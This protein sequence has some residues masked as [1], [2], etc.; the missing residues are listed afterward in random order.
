MPAS[1]PNKQISGRVVPETHKR[2]ED[3]A[4][5]QNPPLSIT[6]LMFVA[7]AEYMSNHGD[8]I[9]VDDFLIG[10]HGG[11]RK[12][13][14]TF[15]IENEIKRL[16]QNYLEC[17]TIAEKW[18]SHPPDEVEDAERTMKAINKRIERLN[19]ELEELD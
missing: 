6:E 16:E 18:G 9:A 14:E 5:A 8:K 7:I 17:Q 2:V 3:F 13:V 12:R 19:R 11:S 15:Q 1:S 10:K 4:K